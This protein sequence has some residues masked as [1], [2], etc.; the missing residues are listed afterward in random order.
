MP[1]INVM[2]AV[3]CTAFYIGFVAGLFALTQKSPFFGYVGVVSLAFAF[4]AVLYPLGVAYV[5]WIVPLLVLAL[6]SLVSLKPV[7]KEKHKWIERIWER[8]S[9]KESQSK[10]LSILRTPVSACMFGIMLIVLLACATALPVSLLYPAVLP[11]DSL[12]ALIGWLTSKHATGVVSSPLDLNSFHLA[13]LSTLSLLLLW[14]AVF[15]WW[16]GRAKWWF[17]LALLGLV[18]ALFG[19]Y[20]F[21]WGQSGYVL[22]L[23]GV[24]LTYH[25]I[26]RFL[27]S[28]RQASGRPG[29]SV[30]ILTLLLVSS[31]PFIEAAFVPQ[32]LF[33]T[34]TAF[35]VSLASMVA[36]GVGSVLTIS[37]ALGRGQGDKP[38]VKERDSRSANSWRWLLLL[39]GLLWNWDYGCIL[40]TLHIPPW[41]GMLALTVLLVALAVPVRQFVHAGSGKAPGEPWSNPL[42]VLI[43]GNAFLTCVLSA[44]SVLSS[45]LS[46]PGQ[47]IAPCLQG[48]LDTTLYLL[49]FFAVFFYLVLLF[50]KR[51]RVLCVPF[52]FASLA[53]PGMPF[54]LSGITI[55]LG[56]FLPF[57]AMEV[58]RLMLRWI[59]GP[60][61]SAPGDAPEKFPWEWPVFWLAIL[62]G[63][64][65]AIAQTLMS[66]PRLHDQ[67]QRLPWLSADW[68]LLVLGLAW[69]GAAVLARWRVS[70]SGFQK[71]SRLLLATLFALWAMVIQLP[72]F[73]AQVLSL[74]YVLLVGLGAGCIGLIIQW[75]TRPGDR[76]PDLWVALWDKD[77]N[78]APGVTPT[79]FESASK[80]LFRQFPWSWPWYA[81]TTAAAV[82]LAGFLVSTLQT[83]QMLAAEQR[84]MLG[85]GLL[86]LALLIYAIGLA[87]RQTVMVWIAIVFSTTT[88]VSFALLHEDLRIFIYTT[89]VCAAVGLAVKLLR[90]AISSLRKARWLRYTSPFYATALLT[91]VCTGLSGTF[92][93]SLLNRVLLLLL[94]WAGVAWVVALVEQFAIGAWLAAAFAL[95][96]LSDIVQS[97]LPDFSLVV[98]VA[99][100]SV[101][102]AVGMRMRGSK[103]GYRL[104]IYMTALL[105]SI[106]SSIMIT[107][108]LVE[109]LGWN[110]MVVDRNVLFTFS[111]ILIIYSMI[112]YGVAFL[113]KCSWPILLATLFG[114]WAIA[115]LQTSVMMVIVIGLGAGI[116]GL[117][118]YRP[119]RQA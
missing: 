82:L 114:A 68:V 50:Q 65:L 43:L 32:R 77:G 86:V 61:A 104:P 96:A 2:W 47:E 45:C 24:A 105:A 12:G 35:A 73:Q 113:E 85:Y 56:L 18:C 81:V 44:N 6:L 20:T 70:S 15:L 9:V 22:A 115:N 78:G 72:G 88:F 23:A 1:T 63:L 64:A 97:R 8:P 112:T 26:H 74:A 79:G 40:L 118:M 52:I 94:L 90:R 57:V 92:D 31:I 95:W 51:P 109:I 4:V 21:H 76:A 111:M 34:P 11:V 17:S 55:W 106:L 27:A 119:G 100:V 107:P 33:Q 58:R 93:P 25:T 14:G 49:L 80:Q 91:A 7:D 54:F 41:I 39:A 60:E 46:G 103:P 84:Y 42:D 87:E 5:W 59:Q 117:G 101:G 108:G 38:Y 3:P 16:S 69:Y 28:R 99:M 19:V 53:V 71:K 30:D 116:A 75:T 67:L 102:V 66:I 13:L 10:R 98:G 37:M 62:C 110:G 48:R 29:L 89:G 83:H 36:I